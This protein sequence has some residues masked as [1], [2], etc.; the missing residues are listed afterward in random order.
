MTQFSLQQLAITNFRAV[1]GTITIQ[2]TEL[3]PG[4]YFVAGDNQVEPRLGANGCGKSTIFT[5][6]ILWCFYGI[7]SRD[8]RPANDVEN[9]SNTAGNT[10]VVCEFVVRGQPHTLTRGRKPSRLLLDGDPVEQAVIDRLLPLNSAALRRSLLIDQFG[11]LFLNLRPEEKSQI[12]SDTLNLGIWIAAAD[13]ASEQGRGIDRT[14][15]DCDRR[16]AA[17]TAVIGDIETQITGLRQ[18]AARFADAQRDHLVVLNAERAIQAATVERTRA[19]LAAAQQ[20]LA[21]TGGA[22]Q[23]AALDQKRAAAQKLAKQLGADTAL[24]DGIDRER[25]RLSRQL[26]AYSADATVCPEC[27]Q[28]VGQEHIQAKRAELEA[29]LV[30]QTERYEALSDR[31]LATG[32]DSVALDAEVVAL[33][34]TLRDYIEVQTA[35]ALATERLTYEERALQRFDAQIT[36]VSNRPNTAEAQI[37]LT[38][39]RLAKVREILAGETA[40]HAILLKQAEGFKFWQKG[41]REIRLER[42]DTTLLELELAANRHAE[43]LGLT[44]WSITFSTERETQKGV[45]HAFNVSLTPPGQTQPISWESYSGGEAQRWQLATSF[46]LAEIMLARAGIDT[47]IEILDEPTAHLSPEGIEDLLLCLKERAV[48]Y[49]R[50]IFIIDHHALDR[51]AFDGVFQVVKTP[52]GVSVSKSH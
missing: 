4:L 52:E 24:R 49:G 41:M 25:L 31:L 5:E 16:I 34:A 14:I 44:G 38:N 36:E 18:Q 51:G 26:T 11:R 46:A 37:D 22:E 7:T 27:G 32:R 23:Q 2:F 17:N 20:A 39:Q 29:L 40:E 35:V 3:V 12:F 42:I 28:A 43:A 33:V 21:S 19:D 48:E 15:A 6:S 50:R 9:W 30:E 8:N 13:K 47:D 45:A 1:T 10:T